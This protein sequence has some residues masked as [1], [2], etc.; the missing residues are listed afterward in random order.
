MVANLFADNYR[1]ADASCFCI[2]I[3][4]PLALMHSVF[5]WFKGC[6]DCAL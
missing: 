3:K 4:A 6:F 2:H 1:D 5:V